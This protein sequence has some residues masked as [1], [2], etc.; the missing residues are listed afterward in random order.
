MCA[1]GSKKALFGP[2][3]A[4]H[5]TKLSKLVIFLVVTAINMLTLGIPGTSIILRHI[6]SWF[7]AVLD[8]AIP[9]SCAQ[10]GGK[11]LFGPKM[12]KVGRLA[13]L[14]TRSKRVQNYQYHMFLTIWR[15]FWPI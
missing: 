12:A 3:M 13:D 10:R 14:P 5:G 8:I 4:K 7:E 9:Q 11:A 6:R 1:G 15:H 2:K